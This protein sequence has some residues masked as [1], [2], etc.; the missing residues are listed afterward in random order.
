ME[1]WKYGSRELGS[2]GSVVVAAVT[3]LRAGTGRAF[4]ISA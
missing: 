3:F 2:F 1:V 4:T